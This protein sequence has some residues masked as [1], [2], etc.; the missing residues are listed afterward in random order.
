LEL[1]PGRLLKGVEINGKKIQK[2]AY[3]SII[4]IEKASVLVYSC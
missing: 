4:Y 3:I 1:S 2:N